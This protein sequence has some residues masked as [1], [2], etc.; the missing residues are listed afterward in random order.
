MQAARW[1]LAGTVLLWHAAGL[2]S[3]SVPTGGDAPHPR[4][5]RGHRRPAQAHP[6]RHPRR[7]PLRRRRGG[8]DLPEPLPKK[9]R[10]DLSV[11]AADARGDLRLRDPAPAGASSPGELRRREEAIQRYKAALRD[12]RVAALLTQERPNLFTQSI[13][14]LEP[15]A[16]VAV[17]AALRRAA[18]PTGRRLRAGVPDG[19]RS[20]LR[21]RRRPSYRRGRRAGA[22]RRCCPAGLRSSHD[23]GLAVDARH[24]ACALRGVTSPSHRIGSRPGTLAAASRRRRHHP[25]QGLRAALR[26]L[27]GETPR[28]SLA[29]PQGDRRGSFL[30]WAAAPRR[31]R[32]PRRDAAE[33]I[34]V[35]D[36]SSSMAGAPLAKAKELVR[37]AARRA[38]PR[39]HLPGGR[40]RRRVERAGRRAP[41]PRKPQNVEYAPRLDR[42]ARRPAAAPT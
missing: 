4:R 26:R 19:R 31:R 5:Q 29:R 6:G 17:Q 2:A 14:N 38:R 15:G 33:L 11:P 41:S 20:P 40:V 12:G 1:L 18:A 30:L 39:R 7:R 27:G 35:V 25:Q 36:T 10:G 24:R 9:D 28:F 21:A 3:T 34:L 32:R 42:R 23:I 22:G 16:E 8:T 13:A 37:Q